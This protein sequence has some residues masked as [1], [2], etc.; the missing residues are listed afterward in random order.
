MTLNT[1]FAHDRMRDDKN[2]SSDVTKKRKGEDLT[3][4]DNQTNYR[5]LWNKQRF[6]LD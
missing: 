1:G 6:R 4:G 5:H 3:G 2:I